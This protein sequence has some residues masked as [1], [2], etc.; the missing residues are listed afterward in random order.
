MRRWV[1]SHATIVHGCYGGAWLGLPVCYRSP[2][3]LI[4]LP[5]IYIYIL[6]VCP[7]VRTCTTPLLN[8][9]YMGVIGKHKYSLWIRLLSR[10]GIAN[11]K[12]LS[13][14]LNTMLS[15]RTG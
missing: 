12:T 5:Y 15:P 2:G 4:A 13:E 14:K 6:G 1:G 11:G 9:R 7:C 3:L 8:N 10:Y